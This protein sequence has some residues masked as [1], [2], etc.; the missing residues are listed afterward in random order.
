MNGKKFIVYLFLFFFLFFGVLSY[1][2]YTDGWFDTF[3]EGGFK[4]LYGD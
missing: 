2:L 3:I 4:A 1:Y